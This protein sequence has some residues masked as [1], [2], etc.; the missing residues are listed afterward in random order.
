MSLSLEFAL[1]AG[2]KD[3]F[4]PGVVDLDDLWYLPWP[5]REGGLENAQSRLLTSYPLS[6]RDAAC[7]LAD[8]FNNEFDFSLRYAKNAHGTMRSAGWL[9]VVEGDQ[10]GR[11]EDPH[12]GSECGDPSSL[13]YESCPR[14]AFVEGE[15][16]AG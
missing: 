8:R 11:F 7:T 14:T 13:G 10:R 12:G 16:G 4:S 1:G 5:C 3:E 15:L 9:Y 6:V 2:V